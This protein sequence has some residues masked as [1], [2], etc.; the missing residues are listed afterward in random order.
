MNTKE[1]VTRGGFL[2]LACILL[3][4]IITVFHLSLGWALAVGVILAASSQIL[5]VWVSH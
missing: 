4:I 5:A 3:V 2:F 1:S